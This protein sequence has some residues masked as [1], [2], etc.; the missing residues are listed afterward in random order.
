MFRDD[1]R[2]DGLFLNFKYRIYGS[3]FESKLLIVNSI[4]NF[5]KIDYF[6]NYIWEILCSIPYDVVVKWVKRQDLYIFGRNLRRN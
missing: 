5:S 1:T 2:Y 4:M 6:E 3:L